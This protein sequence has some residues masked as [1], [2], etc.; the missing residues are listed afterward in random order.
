MRKPAFCICNNKDADQLRGD[1]EADQHL[2]FRYIDNTRTLLPIY[3]I[4]SQ[5]GSFVLVLTLNIEN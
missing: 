2:C 3:K 1:G 4:F 5:Q